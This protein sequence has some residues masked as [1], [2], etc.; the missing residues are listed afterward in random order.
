MFQILVLRFV[1]VS[2]SFHLLYSYVVIDGDKMMMYAYIDNVYYIM[3]AIILFFFIVLVVTYTVDCNVF[4][5]LASFI[6]LVP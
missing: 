5:A 2:K 4:L 3:Y 1:Q 6:F